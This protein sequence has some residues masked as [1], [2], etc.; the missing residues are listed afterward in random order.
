MGFA[1]L[2]IW[3]DEEL[4]NWPFFL[5]FH[6]WIPNRLIS[7]SQRYKARRTSFAVKYLWISVFSKVISSS[8]QSIVYLSHLVFAEDIIVFCK[9]ESRSLCSVELVFTKFSALS[10]LHLNE[11]KTKLYPHK[12]CPK[13][14]RL[15]WCFW[16]SF[17]PTFFKY[18]KFSLVA[19]KLRYNHCS[20]LI[21]KV[22]KKQEV[23]KWRLL[24]FAGSWIIKK[25]HQ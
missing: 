17:G 1:P 21:E 23:R 2:F 19:S 25:C 16:C 11:D 6:K 22:Y 10:G 13:K 14:A 5:S 15:M 7:K 24:S 9:V 3:M 12:S 20:S 18:I 8:S 4:Y